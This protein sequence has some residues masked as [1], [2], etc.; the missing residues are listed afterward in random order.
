MESRSPSV[1]VRCSPF[2]GGGAVE[3]VVSVVRSAN[4]VPAI[5]PIRPHRGHCNPYVRDDRKSNGSQRRLKWRSG[6][7]RLVA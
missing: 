1:A 6:R 7:S 4:G 5:S 2:S 3:P